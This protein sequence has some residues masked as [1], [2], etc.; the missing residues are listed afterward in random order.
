MT[1][2]SGQSFDWRTG[3]YGFFDNREYFN[4]YTDDQTM[5][6]SRIY[7]EAGFSLNDHNSFMGG[8]NYLYEFGSKGDLIAPDIVIYYHGEKGP[9]NFYLGAFPRKGLINQ[10]P[11]LLT[12]TLFYYR[13]NSE[14]MFLEF[15][16]SFGYHNIWIDWTG[17]KTNT[18]RETFLMGGT[19][20][21]GKGAVF[22]EHHFV[23]YH[24]AAPA[25]T[26]PDDHLRD[27]AGLTAVC[28]LNLS[29]KVPVDSAF[30]SSGIGF[31]LD[32]IRNV[33]DF[34]TRIGWYTELGAEHKGFGIH[35]TCYLGDSHTIIYGDR[36]YSSDSYQRIDLYYTKSPSSLIS[37]KL[38][39]S[40]HFVPGVVDYSQMLVIVI[41]LNGS[42]Q[43]LKGL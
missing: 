33:Y 14:G 17:R 37:G 41:N 18:R 2:V 12:D 8:F 26:V 21:F 19:G 22:Y 4:L 39:F 31:S 32:R 25:I 11:M 15:R 1:D 43:L 29:R 23:M 27:N 28:G 38:Q 24:Y 3:F 40:F 35:G 13:P 16:K 9:L 7:A 5:F 36:F 30:I 20:R 34:R 10:P 42:K 6:G